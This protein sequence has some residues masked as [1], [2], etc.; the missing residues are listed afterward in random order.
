MCCPTSAPT[1]FAHKTSFPP[2][3]LILNPLQVFHYFNKV[4][5]SAPGPDG[6]SAWIIRLCS[7][8]LATPLSQIFLDSL[9]TGIIPDSW[10]HAIVTPVPKIPQP[11]SISDYRP[12]SVT[13][14]FSRVLERVVVKHYLL[15]AFLAQPGSKLQFAY[16]PSGSPTC[17]L[18]YLFHFVTHALESNKFV[19]CLFIDFSKAF[20]RVDRGILAAKLQKLNLP[21]FVVHWVLSF[22]SYRTQSVKIAGT[23]SSSASIN[24][25]VIQGSVLGPILFDI[26]TQDLTAISGTNSVFKFADDVGVLSPEGSDIGLEKEF[27]NIKEWAE[28]N[29]LCINLNKTK[30]IT[31]HRP[32]PHL[33]L[34][35]TI[36]CIPR[37]SEVTF[38]G[39]NLSDN[40]KF[41]SHITHLLKSCTPVMYLLRCLKRKGLSAANLEIVF[42]S[43]IVTKLLYALP[44]WFGFLSKADSSRIDAL[45]KKGNKYGYCSKVLTLAELSKGHDVNLFSK[46]QQPNHCL[47]FL[48]PPQKLLPIELRPK[49]HNFILPQCTSSFYKSSFINRLLFKNCF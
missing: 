28:C 16:K 29:K 10:R 31:F 4:S 36:C 46:I 33:S 1:G 22:L 30:E 37:C 38:L 43:L 7:V 44:A 41:S 23:V 35:P 17:A 8:E 34:P 19:R 11:S 27:I 49:K 24:L 32:N 26:F 13:S 42:Q 3:A 20:D 39:V 5:N 40:F 15:P 48:L 12:I 2:P 18:I 9:S 47:H 6:L 21:H 45:L 14:I 25:G